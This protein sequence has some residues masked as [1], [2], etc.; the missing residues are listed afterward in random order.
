MTGANISVYVFRLRSVL[1]AACETD[2][3]QAT[4]PACRDKLR[5]LIEASLSLLLS[6]SG[7]A[8]P[9]ELSK[10]IPANVAKELFNHLCLHG[11]RRMQILTGLFR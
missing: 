11:N 5:F 7:G 10:A 3:R 1:P 9:S 2:A 4:H 8:L 6:R